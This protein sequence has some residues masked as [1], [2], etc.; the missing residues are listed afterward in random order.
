[1]K[2]AIA[3]DEDHVASGFGCAPFYRIVDIVDG[4]AR[5]TLIIPNPGIHHEFWADLFVRNSIGF[6]IAG[7]MGPTARAVLM[8]SGIQPVLGVK[9]QIDDVIRLFVAGE[10]GGHRP[11]ADHATCGECAE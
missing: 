11:T 4:R 2:I 1:V 8:G 5:D 9:G 10:L 6:V 7:S 3:S